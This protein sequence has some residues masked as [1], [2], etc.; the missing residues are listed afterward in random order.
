MRPIISPMALGVSHAF[1]VV[2]PS[3]DEHVLLKPFRI[4]TPAVPRANA[5]AA[6]A[7]PFACMAAFV[8]LLVVLPVY[9]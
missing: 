7:P 6:A 2:S 3:E 4:F 8:I 1:I 9:F 5:A